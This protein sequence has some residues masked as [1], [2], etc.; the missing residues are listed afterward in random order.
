MV[1]TPLNIRRFLSAF[2]LCISTLAT[3][4]YPQTSDIRFEHLSL[5]QGL[6]GSI[7]TSVVQDHQGFMWFSTYEGLDRFDGYDFVGFR[8]DPFDSASLSSNVLQKILVS[9]DGT[10]WIATREEG[11]N[12]FDREKQHFRV[13]R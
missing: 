3:V 7:V 9:R 4:V 5:E 10:L 1:N 8:Y 2:L 11:L 12:R 6:S 13:F